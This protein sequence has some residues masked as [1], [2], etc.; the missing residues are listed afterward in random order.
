MP[1][2]DSVDYNV[3]I[4]G[5][6][7]PAHKLVTTAESAGADRLDVA[8]LDVNISTLDGLSPASYLNKEIEIQRIVGVSEEIVHWGK[9]T[10]LPMLINPRGET[11]QVVSRT[12]LYHIGGKIDGYYV[13]DPITTSARRVDGDLV[14]NPLID[15]LVYG[16][17]NDTQTT[18]GGDPVFLDPESVRSAAAVT[19][20]GANITNWTL[21]EA[22][23]YLIW[24]LNTDETYVDNESLVNL[25]AIFDDPNAV[26]RDVRLPR[27]L[28][29]AQALDQLLTPLG[30]QWRVNRPELGS[31][32][33]AFWKRGAGGTLRTVKHQVWGSTLNLANQNTETAGITF[34]ISSLGN[35]VTVL[36]GFGEYELTVELLRAWPTADDPSA[37]IADGLC[38]DDENF[39]DNVNVLRKWVLNEAGDYIGLRPEIDGVF[40]SDLR[41]ALVDAGL[42]TFFVPRRRR[43]MPTLRLDDDGNPIGRIQGVEV[44]YSN[45]ETENWL[46]VDLLDCGCT[47]LER[48]AGVY[49]DA[50]RLPEEFLFMPA[51]LRIRAT[52]TLQSDFR[53]TG[54]GLKLANSPNE[55]VVPVVVSAPDRFRSRAILQ[56]LSKYAV[57]PANQDVDGASNASPIVITADGHGLVTGDTV[58]I[59]DVGGNL[60]AN[61][62]WVITRINSNTFSLNGSVGSGNYTAGG[63]IVFG[64]GA[65]LPSLRAADQAAIVPFAVYAR[66]TWD[67]M[68]SGGTVQLEGLD[69]EY[70]VG[71]RVQKIAGKE[72]SF[73]G[74]T[75]SGVYPQIVAIERNVTQQVMTLHLEHFRDP[76]LLPTPSRG[77]SSRFAPQS[78][79]GR[80]T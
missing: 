23:Y 63:T 30:Y 16:N 32:N 9:V 56:G 49:F 15:G 36:G 13:Y 47:L 73:E 33:L 55:D 78:F 62:L 29:L 3:Y 64:G 1:A 39:A 80:T 19:L 76:L 8:T 5:V 17:L 46:P 42:A 21:A 2:R 68:R 45:D 41:D 51:N 48:E 61:G 6:L 44:E 57:G 4:D 77:T 75:S 43:M 40:T 60:A 50:N 70:E 28:Y 10:Q 71:D 25:Q 54:V 66:N 38:K 11:L 35:Q 7:A 14:F 79:R 74:K 37:G 24:S 31:R 12:E 18:A 72:I 22:V 27:G 58:W 67:L 65:V 59:Y 20:Q 69:H 26:I 53:L 52:F 34:D